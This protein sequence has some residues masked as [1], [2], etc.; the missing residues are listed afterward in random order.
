LK[1][2]AEDIL[3]DIASQMTAKQIEQAKA[4]AKEWKATHPP[5]SFFPP[6]LGF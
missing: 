6:K 4:F 5:L 3:P 2:Y 1:E